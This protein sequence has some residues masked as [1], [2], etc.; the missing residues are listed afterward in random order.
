MLLNSLVC[1]DYCISRGC[2]PPEFCG[3]SELPYGR[4]LAPEGGKIQNWQ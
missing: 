2:K 1:V 4:T 3:T